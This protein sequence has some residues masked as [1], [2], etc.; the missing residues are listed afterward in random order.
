[1]AAGLR[2]ARGQR[3]RRRILTL[4]PPRL[5]RPSAEVAPDLLGLVLE[6]TVGG[7]RTSGRIVEVEAYVGRPDPA[8]HAAERI[9]RTARNAP[10]Y[11]APGTAYVYAIYGMHRCMNV[12][13][14]GVDLPGAVLIRALEPLEG[15]EHM[16]LRRGRERDLTN[17]PA[18]LTQ[19]LGIDLEHNGHAL[20]ASP[21]RLLATATETEKHEVGVSG[22]IGIRH[23]C[24]W[25][26]RF[27]VSGHP[28]VSVRRPPP[29]RTSAPFRAAL[30]RG[31]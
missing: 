18:R 22:R 24:D 15:R 11:G 10:M 19:A 26:L 25:P 5:A 1:M 2:A 12:V 27:F 16:A 17:G 31:P 30:E 28:D 9:G 29:S 6:S 23:A 3:R 13:T 14:D 21:L 4:A 8:S 7:V 20:D